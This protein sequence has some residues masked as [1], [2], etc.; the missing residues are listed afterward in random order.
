MPQKLSRPQKMINAQIRAWVQG[1]GPEIPIQKVLEGY[2]PPD[3]KGSG[4]YFTSLEIGVAALENLQMRVPTSPN[5]LRGLDPCAGIGHFIY[6]VIFLRP[7]MTFDAYE[8]EGECV[9]IGRKLFPWVNWIHEMPFLA[10]DQ[11]EGQYDL[12]LCNSPIGIKRGVAAGKMMCK[13]RCS[14]SEHIFLE[15]SLRA[16]K[17]GGQAVLL[18]AANYLD[19]C[20]ARLRDWITERQFKLAP[21]LGPLP[22]SK[23]SEVP[24]YAYYF[25]YQKDEAGN[26]SSTQPIISFKT[27]REGDLSI[28][29]TT[30][31]SKLL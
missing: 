23:H 7:I 1:D 16:L 21:P 11:I 9:E 3:I 27:T 15:L 20:P 24:L 12:V 19:N 13:N 8:I 10:M 17:P 30:A 22:R 5:K 29:D 25:T 31:T 18:G 28:Y 4:Q 2:T 6:Q 26:S 14:R